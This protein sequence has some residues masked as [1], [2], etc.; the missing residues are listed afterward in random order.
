MPGVAA[1][2]GRGLPQKQTN[3]ADIVGRDGTPAA[4]QSIGRGVDPAT[5]PL[6]PVNAG[7]YGPLKLEYGRLAQGHRGRSSSTAAPPPPSATPS[8]TPSSSGRSAPSTPSSS[9]APSS[10]IGEDLPP[11]RASRC[12]DIKTA[13]ALFDRDGRYDAISIDAKPGTSGAELARRIKPLL[14]AD[15]QVKDTRLLGHAGRGGLGRTM[16]TIRAFLL[17]SAASR[18]WSARS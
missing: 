2:A 13:Q 1:A 18:C 4:T 3:V 10:Y 11:G 5:L 14:P 9:P 15:L 7:A 6:S 16:S 17:A 8:A 12:W